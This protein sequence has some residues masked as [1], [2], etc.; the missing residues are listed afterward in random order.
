MRS[1]INRAT[2]LQRAPLFAML[3]DEQLTL[4]AANTDTHAFKRGEMIFH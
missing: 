4:L 3:T 2:L 1:T